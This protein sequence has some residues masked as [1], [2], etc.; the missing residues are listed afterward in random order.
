MCV[1]VWLTLLIAEDI[2]S[3][4]TVNIQLITICEVN[5]KKW[6]PLTCKYRWHDLIWLRPTSEVR[7]C[8]RYSHVKGPHFWLLTSQRVSNCF[9]YSSFLLM[10]QNLLENHQIPIFNST[11]REFGLNPWLQSN[12]DK[13]CFLKFKRWKQPFCFWKESIWLVHVCPTFEKSNSLFSHTYQ[14]MNGLG[15]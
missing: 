14:T 1:D 10:L 3:N 12:D 15:V 9:Y 2:K 13:S 5:N 8:H 4:G 6:G 11:L 7:S